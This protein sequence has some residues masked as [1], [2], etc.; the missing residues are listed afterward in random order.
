MRQSRFTVSAIA[1]AVII[2]VFLYEP[3]SGL[4]YRLR[5]P[6]YKFPIALDGN[7]AVIRC[8][9][10][11]SGEFGAKRR[12]GRAHAGIDIAARIGAPVYAA[13]SG[14]V[15]TGNISHGY[16]KYIMI[17]HPDGFQTMY[18]HLSGWN[19]ITSQR[20]KKGDVIG[21]VGKTGNAK[22]RAIQPH[23]HFE[24]RKRG[25]PIDPAGLLK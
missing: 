6:F 11:G 12:N 22:S 17:A 2:T 14:I 24:I 7:K 20:V 1:A 5:E 21:F 25:E 13:K 8:D 15:F 9:N 19:V 10:H 23:L 18:G 4:L 16:G 3:V